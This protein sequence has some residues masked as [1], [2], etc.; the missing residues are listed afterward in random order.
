MH[1]KN[2]R[3]FCALHAAG[4]P[5]HCDSSAVLLKVRLFVIQTAMLRSVERVLH[6]TGFDVRLGHCMHPRPSCF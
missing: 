3:I 1:Q 4:D 5:T 2:P 6:L